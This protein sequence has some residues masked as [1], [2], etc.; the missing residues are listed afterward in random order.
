MHEST[1]E[2]AE[3]L[4]NGKAMLDTSFGR[5]NVNGLGD[6]LERHARDLPELGIFQPKS[7]V[8]ILLRSIQI[9]GDEVRRTGKVT[10]PNQMVLE[11]FIECFTQFTTLSDDEPKSVE[12]ICEEVVAK[13]RQLCQELDS[14][15]V[16]PDN[17][18]HILTDL[19]KLAAFLMQPE[20]GMLTKSNVETY[21]AAV[22]KIR[23]AL[24]SAV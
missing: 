15:V 8:D 2:L 10:Y 1:K 3:V 23:L 11:Y 6:M 14:A 21:K 5:K 12:T 17:M 4:L 18:V 20:T 13:Q 9:R 16:L 22:E 19:L 24:E 7:L